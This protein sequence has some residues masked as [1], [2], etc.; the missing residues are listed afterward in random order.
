V[1]KAFYGAFYERSL[2]KN[3]TKGRNH[4]PLFR[5]KHTRSIG[6]VQTRWILCASAITL[7]ASATASR[8]IA[9]PSTHATAR[10]DSFELSTEASDL[11]AALNAAGGSGRLIGTCSASDLGK[12][13]ILACVFRR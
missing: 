12:L 13:Q 1:K 8:V 3:N 4:S 6:F 7:N 5:L 11:A 9:P 10:L 2:G